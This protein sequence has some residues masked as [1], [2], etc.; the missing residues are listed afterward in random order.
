MLSSRPRLPG[1]P[2][3]P[4]RLDDAGDAKPAWITLLTTEHYNL[5][6]QRAS[7]IS[8]TN[9]RT[10]VYLGAVSAGLIALGFQAA[11]HGRSAALSARPAVRMLWRPQ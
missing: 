7:T 4:L 6:V 2:V 5:Q 8:E 11:G 9:G 1:P 10:S 3:R